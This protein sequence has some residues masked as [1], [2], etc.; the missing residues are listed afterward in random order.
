MVVALE[1]DPLGTAGTA[2]TMAPLLRL[3]SELLRENEREVGETGRALLVSKYADEGRR[4][5]E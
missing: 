1:T 5:S 3:A 4:R 2:L